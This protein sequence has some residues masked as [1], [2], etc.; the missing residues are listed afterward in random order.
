MEV[1]T[2]SLP[3]TRPYDMIIDAN[4]TPRPCVPAAP[5]MAMSATAHN[6]LEKLSIRLAELRKDGA[7]LT[8]K[9]CESLL[10]HLLGAKNASNSCSELVQALRLDPIQVPA[11]LDE[12]GEEESDD[13]K[14][15][16]GAPPRKAKSPAAVRKN[17]PEDDLF[18]AGDISDTLTG[19]PGRALATR[20]LQSAIS[21]GRPR[22]AS[23]F[24]VD[25]LRYLSCRYGTEAGQHAIRH[26]GEYLRQKMPSDTILFRWG[27]SS[28]L[29]IFDH[30]GSMADARG[31]IEH[32]SS[33]KVKLNYETSLRSAL[34]NLTSLALPLALA[35]AGSHHEATL[36]LDAFVG[37]HSIRQPV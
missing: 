12:D 27:G 32:V 28:F 3:Q 10:A 8:E 29:G 33:Q 34:L 26:Y 37:A 14:L 24:A 31:I 2:E 35:T 25:R 36:E 6:G 1:A 13:S 18:P 22:Y 17:N 23:I 19:L 11:L 21:I 7:K 5:L 30:S 20:A 4:Q 15:A 9:E 16:E